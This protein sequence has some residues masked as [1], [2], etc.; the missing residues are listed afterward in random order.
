VKDLKSVST[1]SPGYVPPAPGMVSDPNQVRALPETGPAPRAGKQ[2]VV[3]QSEPALDFAPPTSDNG[4]TQVTYSRMGQVKLWCEIQ[5]MLEGAFHTV[6]ECDQETVNVV[7]PSFSVSFTP[8]EGQG[9]IG[10]DIRL[11]IDSQP[12]RGGRPDRL[13][14]VRPGHVQPAG[15]HPNAREIGFKVKD[16]KPVV[17]KALARVPITATASPTSAPPTPASSSR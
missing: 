10:Q 7:A 2:K 17:L 12:G 14:L 9:R 13:P 5:E 8:P 16:A 11:R 15:T 3:W 1:A 6:G 4:R